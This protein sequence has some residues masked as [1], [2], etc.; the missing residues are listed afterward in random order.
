MAISLNS[1]SKHGA[2]RK[3]EVVTKGSSPC[4]WSHLSSQISMN[5]SSFFFQRPWLI[6]SQW[7]TNR[8]QP[9]LERLRATTDPESFLWAMLPHAARTFSPCILLLPRDK[10]RA[11]AVCY[12]YCRCL[13][14]NEDLSPT[15]G[16]S[17]T[18]FAARFTERPPKKLPPLENPKIQDLRAESHLLLL[19]CIERV[20]A[21]YSSLDPVPQ[22]AIA[23]C[24]REMSIGM[25]QRRDDSMEDMLSYCRSVI[26][27]PVVFALELMLERKLDSNER[28]TAMRVG[29]M[30]QL[31]NIC[32]DIEKDLSR[33]VVY[34]A[35]LRNAVDNETIR[36]VREDMV[37]IALAR[38]SAYRQLMEMLEPPRFQL[39]RASAVLM[40]LFTNRYYDACVRQ[41]GYE[42]WYA[43]R[44]S[45][46][47]FASV[48]PSVFSYR[49][50]MR[51][52]RSIEK[53]INLFCKTYL[54]KPQPLRNYGQLSTAK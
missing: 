28:E 46:E 47:L 2:N 6:L 12:L 29:E 48:F 24:V 19:N 49:Y 26:G 33:G 13:D 27:V 45:A 32:R 5:R 16:P 54:S 15:S 23:R 52:V 17:V 44:S 9:N 41:L 39:G 38:V 53:T 43:V 7:L 51:L 14:T 4:S 42:G 21:V 34:D 50:T 25:Q 10:A 20:D 18:A 11:A 22:E 30:V 1:C 8:D 35:R 31:A 37:R 40:L 36:K 3:I